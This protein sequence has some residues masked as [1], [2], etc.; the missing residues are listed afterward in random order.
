MN[1]VLKWLDKHDMLVHMFV[2]FSMFY[3][4]PLIWVSAFQPSMVSSIIASAVIGLCLIFVIYTSYWCAS[5]VTRVIRDAVARAALDEIR[6][7]TLDLKIAR[8]PVID[9]NS[10]TTLVVENMKQETRD[11]VESLKQAV[12]Q[13]ESTAMIVQSDLGSTETVVTAPKKRGRPA[14]SAKKEG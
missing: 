2:M 9:L 10:P 1:Q 11:A 8:P 14:K 6:D 12:Q 3:G 4:I 7:T 5:A 13:M